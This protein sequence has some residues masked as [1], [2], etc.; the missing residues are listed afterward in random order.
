ME[1][2]SMKFCTFQPIP[3]VFYQCEKKI[4]R[5][6]RDRRL[7]DYRVSCTIRFPYIYKSI[8]E[9]NGADR[10]YVLCSTKMIQTLSLHITVLSKFIR[11]EG[12]GRCSGHTIQIFCRSLS[13]LK[14]KLALNIFM[15]KNC[16]V[17]HSIN[18][19]TF[20]SNLFCSKSC[21]H[22]RIMSE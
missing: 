4:S 10:D 12:S 2:Q 13:S 14:T 7:Y 11:A 17:S 3:F 8:I 18:L 20:E 9:T 21:F 16:A 19:Y 15:I 1:R 6:V 5:A 22:Q